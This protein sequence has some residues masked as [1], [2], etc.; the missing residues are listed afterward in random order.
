VSCGGQRRGDSGGKTTKFEV[1][2]GRQRS[3]SWRE[4]MVVLSGKEEHKEIFLEYSNPEK[5][6]IY[7]TRNKK[8]CE[9]F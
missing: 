1:S 7:K 2:G 8:R 9:A 5:S 3:D 4:I 6:L